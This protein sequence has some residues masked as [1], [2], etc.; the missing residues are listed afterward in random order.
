VKRSVISLRG[1]YKQDF[2]R[3]HGRNE[4]TQNRRLLDKS[5]NQPLLL[6]EKLE[7]ETVEPDSKEEPSGFSVGINRGVPGELLF[8][9][10]TG[11][12]TLLRPNARLMRPYVH[13]LNVADF[14]GI[15]AG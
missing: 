12:V 1:N 3:L 8:R 4:L 15:R 9:V 5:G 2:H 6:Y 13:P 11:H 14:K 7:S 10:T